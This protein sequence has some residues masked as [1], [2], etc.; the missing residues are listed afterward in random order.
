MTHIRLDYKFTSREVHKVAY[1]LVATPTHSV[2]YRVRYREGTEEKEKVIYFASKKR[3]A[4]ASDV[5][6]KLT[7]VAA[8]RLVEVK[9]V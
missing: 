1:S 7:G 8:L 6:A 5:V 3:Q 9:Y 4:Q 2:G